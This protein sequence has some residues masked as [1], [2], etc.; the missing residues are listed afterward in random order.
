MILEQTRDA[1]GHRVLIACRLQELLIYLVR[2]IED[3]R[4]RAETAGDLQ[5][6]VAGTRDY[7][8]GHFFEPITIP[9]LAAMAGCSYRRF[10]TLFKVQ[11]GTT[12]NTYITKRRIDYACRRLRE[13]GNIAS[14]ALEA[15]FEDLS[16]FYRVFKKETGTTPARLT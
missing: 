5:R 1:P 11:T 13:T 6:A 10:T 7:I 4:L 14:A 12:V 9:R 3:L 16:H 15:G 8:D 2:S